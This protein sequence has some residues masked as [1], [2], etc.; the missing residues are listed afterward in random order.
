MHG[1][2]MSIMTPLLSDPALAKAP[3]LVFGNKIDIDGAA[4]EEELR[5]ALGLTKMTT[6]KQGRPSSDDIRPIEVFMCSVLRRSGFLPG[7]EW[8]SEQL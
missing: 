5:E 8:L 7:I 2:F 6:G 3:F 1:F 4:S